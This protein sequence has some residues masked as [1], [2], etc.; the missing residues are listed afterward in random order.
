MISHITKAS[1]VERHSVNVIYILFV[2]ETR[3]IVS[4]YKAYIVPDQVAETETRIIQE[5]PRPI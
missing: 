2:A 4:G 1:L 5:Y 3:S